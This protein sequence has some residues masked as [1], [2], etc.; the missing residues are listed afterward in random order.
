MNDLL[1]YFI[2]FYESGAER[3]NHSASRYRYVSKSRHYAIGTNLAGVLP[4]VS[5]FCN[6]LCGSPQ[7]Y[8]AGLKYCF[9]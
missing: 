3:D 5:F 8:F 1:F 6:R 4:A 7:L 2:V 9:R